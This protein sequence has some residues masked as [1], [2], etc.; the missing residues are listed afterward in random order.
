M[1]YLK[2][3]FEKLSINKYYVMWKSILFCIYARDVA[4]AFI[5]W[6]RLDRDPKSTLE[7]FEN[8]LI[9]EPENSSNVYIL[10][11]NS[12]NREETLNII[13]KNKS[14]KVLQLPK[15]EYHPAPKHVVKA[16]EES[17]QINEEEYKNIL[18]EPI[19]SIIITEHVSVKRGRG[20][21]KGSKNKT[22]SIESYFEE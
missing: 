16:L 7:A 3:G 17:I 15:K 1:D 8:L 11:G 12:L 19:T 9:K 21:P 18:E 13:N 2:R 10:I 20:R 6:K 4:D 14:S 22:A 5:P